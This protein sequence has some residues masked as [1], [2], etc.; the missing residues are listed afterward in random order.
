M[1]RYDGRMT[2]DDV[3]PVAINQI[4]RAPA[5]GPATPLPFRAE[6]IGDMTSEQAARLIATRLVAMPADRHDAL[7][8]DLA[9][10]LAALAVVASPGATDA[11]RQRALALVG[12]LSRAH[13]LEVDDGEAG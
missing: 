11:D 13:G 1:T 4:L 7:R 6:M 9:A 12:E 8:L 3:F 10:A 2:D 5:L